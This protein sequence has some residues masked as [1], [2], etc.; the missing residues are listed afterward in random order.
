MTPVT[1]G[2]A[3]SFGF[4]DRTGLATPGH[5]EAMKR[6]GAGIE[7]IFPQQSI[8]EMTRTKRTPQQ[9]MDDALAGA[10]A[11][12]WKGKTGADADHL[13]TYEDVEVTAAV[14]FTFFTIDPSGHVDQH[15]DDYGEQELREAERVLG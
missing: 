15:A 11:A 10:E 5:V 8:R 7:P 12:G 1:L 13:K 2:L 4:G 6:S 14:G 3:P 9:V